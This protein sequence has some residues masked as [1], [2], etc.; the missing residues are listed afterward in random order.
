MYNGLYIYTGPDLSDKS[1][2]IAKK[3][4][5]QINCFNENGFNMKVIKINNNMNLL[6]KIKFFSPFLTSTYEKEMVNLSDLDINWENIKFI[7][8]R[9]IAICHGFIKMLELLKYKKNLTILLEIPTYPIYGEYKGIKKMANILIDYYSKFLRKYI[10]YIVTYSLDEEIWGIKTVKIS[11]A[12]NFTELKMKMPSNTNDIHM[13]AVANF[14]FWHGYDRLIMGLKNYYNL[15]QNREV[16]LHMVGAGPSIKEYK[17]LVN[18][19]KLSRYVIFEGKL[20]DKD[21]DFIYNKCNLAIDALGRHRSGIYYN[22]SLKGKEYGAK[23]LPII[24]GVKTELDNYDEYPYYF[25]VPSD[26]SPI[27]IKSVINFF[28]T[29]YQSKEEDVISNIRKL[30]MDYFDFPIAFKPVITVINND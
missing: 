8:I 4:R 7:Y 3:I 19:L 11:N 10:N 27:N 15:K 29:V 13:I 17:Q 28:D 1:S 5:N 24:S 6:D 23:G 21:L 2:G 12:V 9:K 22:S 30:N 20:Y 14:D 26:D 18:K 16:F 25:R